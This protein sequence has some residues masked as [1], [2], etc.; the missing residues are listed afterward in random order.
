M[1]RDSAYVASTGAC[2]PLEKAKG[3]LHTVVYSEELSFAP[4]GTKIEVDYSR[5]HFTDGSKKVDDKEKYDFKHF[6]ISEVNGEFVCSLYLEPVGLCSLPCGK[7][8]P[9]EGGT[10]LLPAWVESP[11]KAPKGGDE[12][13]GFARRAVSP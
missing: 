11:R 1:E 8:P 9:S 5:H 2:L 12:A 6:H 7:A 4:G 3:F 10:P 13:C